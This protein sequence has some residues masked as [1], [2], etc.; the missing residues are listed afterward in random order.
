[1]VRYVGVM[2]AVFS[3]SMMARAEGNEET[4]QATVVEKPVAAAAAVASGSGGATCTQGKNTRTVSIVSK[5]ANKSV[6]CEVHYKKVTEQPDHDQ[7]I[8][9]ANNEVSFCE[10]KAKAFAEKLTGMGWMC[11]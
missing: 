2:L 9:T 7:V 10:A 6:P 4:L 5:D 1:M 8:Y 3:M 11:Q